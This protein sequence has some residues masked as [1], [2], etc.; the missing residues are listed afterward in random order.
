MTNLKGQTANLGEKIRGIKQFLEIMI[1]V[2]WKKN[3][4]G[5]MCN[6]KTQI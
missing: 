3:K 2:P 4:H 5:S 1:I 6:L